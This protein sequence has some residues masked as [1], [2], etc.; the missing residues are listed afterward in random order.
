MRLVVEIK[1][2]KEARELTQILPRVQ[3]DILIKDYSMYHY[4]TIAYLHQW[5]TTFYSS[6]SSN[7]PVV[8][9]SELQEIILL[10]QLGI[11]IQDAINQITETQQ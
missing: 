5:S 6:M 1:S 9:V 2:L 3:K 7:S 11:T 8:S 10:Q 4:V